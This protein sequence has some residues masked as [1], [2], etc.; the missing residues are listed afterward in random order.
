MGMSKGAVSLLYDLKATVELKGSVCQLGRQTTYVT[1]EKIQLIA[2]KFG[3]NV[4][5]ISV[6]P[7]SSTKNADD[8]YLFKSLGFDSVQS[9]DYS[10]YEGAT[11]V[12]DLNNPVPEAFHEQYDVIFDG[13]TVEHI[14]NFPGCLKNI[15]KMLK[16]GGIIMHMS[17]S[18]NHVDHGF[19]MFSPMVFYGYYSSN[20]YQILKSCL[21]EYE[22]DHAGHPWIVYEYTPGSIDD[23]ACGG[24]G[25]KL[26]GIWFVAR[27]G[28]DASC[29]VVPQQGSYLRA[30][31]SKAGGE[32]ADVTYSA[33]A[34]Q[35]RQ[36]PLNFIKEL[37]RK[38]RHLYSVT[39]GIFP[40]VRY[41]ISSLVERRR[42]PVIARY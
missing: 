12:L 25:N 34:M 31:A 32:R 39:K 9:I 23:L 2:K 37:V 19:Y 36:G 29:D 33:P 16:P 7:K 30:W 14:F 1:E 5:L 38:N 22:E 35:Y 20:R 26:L 24:W 3:F 15:H 28:E 6:P 13:G 40:K 10:D 42:P 17:P 11:H 8:I 21:F 4:P 41:L 27:K 18:H